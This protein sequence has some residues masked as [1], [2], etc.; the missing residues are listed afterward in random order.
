MP[1][2]DP[3]RSE[4]VPDGLMDVVRIGKSLID[5]PIKGILWFLKQ[6]GLQASNPRV[7]TDMAEY[8]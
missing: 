7:E 4:T 6:V 3:L 2:V 8:H 1:G 5:N